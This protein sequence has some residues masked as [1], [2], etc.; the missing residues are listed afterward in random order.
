MIPVAMA[1]M[2]MIAARHGCRQG[3]QKGRGKELEGI[4]HDISSM[5]SSHTDCFGTHFDQMWFQGMMDGKDCRKE[6]LVQKSRKECMYLTL[7]Q[8]EMGL[9]AIAD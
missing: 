7:I 5:Q 3:N 6:G 8:R 9:L 1:V 4:S 2:A